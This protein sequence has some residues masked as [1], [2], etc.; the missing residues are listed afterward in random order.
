MSRRRLTLTATA[1]LALSLAIPAQAADVGFRGLLELVAAG[2]G[3][4]YDYNVLTRG[5]ASFDAY[6][7]RL[8]ANARVNPKLELFG[9]LV[10]R[11]ASAFYVDGAYLQF[12]P[13]ADRDLHVLAGKVPWAIGTYAPR[14]YSNKNPLIGTPLMYQYHTTLV[15]YALPPNADA[16]LATAGSGTV[17]GQLFWRHHEPRNGAGG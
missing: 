3:P 9:N 7:V 10:L 16:L 11:D 12:T 1:A 8:F 2:R 4:A 13:S 6:G 14:T 5:D 15:W 17:R